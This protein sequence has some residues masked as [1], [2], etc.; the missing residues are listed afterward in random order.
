MIH[1]LLR[2]IARILTNS[3]GI[4][5]MSYFL[6]GVSFKGDIIDLLFAGLVLAVANTFIKPIL[7]FV[8]GPLIVL[9][10]GLFTI[11]V[12]IIIL[13]LA[14][15]FVPQLTIAGF[16]S[17]F[18]GVIILSILNAITHTVVKKKTS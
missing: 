5:I 1:L 8:S 3:A 6:P 11:I 9:T 2:F 18:W 14:A 7:K 13:W 15:W 16:W 17:Y 4:L 10:M 12:N